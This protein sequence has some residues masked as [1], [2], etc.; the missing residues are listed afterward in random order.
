MANLKLLGR[1]SSLSRSGRETPMSASKVLKYVICLV[2]LATPGLA[3]TVAQ[4]KRP[5][6]PTLRVAARY[7]SEW[8]DYLAPGKEEVEFFRK[9][10]EETTDVL[11]D[12]LKAKRDAARRHAAYILG[13]IGNVSSI[14]HLVECLRKEKDSLVRIYL[15]IALRDIGK[16]TPGVLDAIRKVYLGRDRDRQDPDSIDEQIYASGAAYVLSQD[17][18]ERQERLQFVIGWLRIPEGNVSEKK[19]IFHM[20]RGVAA[21]EALK[22]MKGAT[23]AIPPLKKLLKQKSPFTW[24]LVHVPEAISI[25][26]RSEKKRKK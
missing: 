1:G 23:S 10:S 4:P 24:I 11:L 6:E 2:G 8:V 17:K 19:A 5:S 25:L 3:Q 7:I 16:P 15:C 13:E 26:E 21:V 18:R 22:H 12:C 14:P 9:H 20:N